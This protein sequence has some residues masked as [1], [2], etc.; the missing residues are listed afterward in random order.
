ML[1]VKTT[2]R[3][4]VDKTVQHELSTIGESWDARFVSPSVSHYRSQVAANSESHDHDNANDEA[5]V[6]LHIAAGASG[7]NLHLGTSSSSSTSDAVPAKG[8]QK[9][10]DIELS[11][12]DY[13]ICNPQIIV[14]LLRNK[15]WANILVSGL[16]D[17]KWRADPYTHLQMPKEKKFLVRKLVMGF[18]ADYSKPHNGHD[19]DESDDDFDDFIAGKGKGLIFLLHGQPGLGKTLTAGE[20]LIRA[21]Y[22]E[23]QY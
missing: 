8:R 2:Q 16:H 5:R 7:I 23:V 14:F 9:A 15:I 12:E 18:T 21:W 10:L 3:V 11:D 20:G 1:T 17:I 6:M 4:I 13:M 22:C 19:E